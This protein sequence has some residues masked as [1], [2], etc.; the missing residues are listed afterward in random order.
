MEEKS[1]L[2]WCSRRRIFDN[3]WR[4]RTTLSPFKSARRTMD[5]FVGDSNKERKIHSFR[6]LAFSCKYVVVSCCRLCRVAVIEKWPNLVKDM[7]V[8]TSINS[9]RSDDKKTATI[10]FFHFLQNMDERAMTF[11]AASRCL[12]AQASNLPAFCNI[13][14]LHRILNGRQPA[15]IMSCRNLMKWTPTISSYN[16][17]DISER[18]VGMI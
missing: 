17:R 16:K 18:F 9:T 15:V 8:T 10:R 7:G 11:R 14:C 6:C 5:S 3:S 2:F 13:S 12:D 4:R 1:R